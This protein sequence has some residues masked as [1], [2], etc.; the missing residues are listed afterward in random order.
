MVDHTTVGQPTGCG[1]P[2]QSR[3]HPISATVGQPTGTNSHETNT[4]SATVGQP[5]GN[6]SDHDNSTLPDD[7]QITIN[8]PLVGFQTKKQVALEAFTE[9]MTGDFEVY[10]E[11]KRVNFSQWDKVIAAVILQRHRKTKVV[12]RKD[13]DNRHHSI[14]DFPLNTIFILSN[15]NVRDCKAESPTQQSTTGD[16]KLPDDGNVNTQDCN[17][18]NTQPEVVYAE[19]RNQ[20][21]EEITKTTIDISKTT[22]VSTQN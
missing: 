4:P 20:L 10:A 2:A 14:K 1:R 8:L 11:R 18:V 16:M 7:D 17:R 3:G 6:E 13:W 15:D 12:H 19:S 9:T 21:E 22:T 5:T